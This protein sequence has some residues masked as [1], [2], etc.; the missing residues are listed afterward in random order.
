MLGSGGVLEQHS[1]ALT[2]NAEAVKQVANMV[3]S[4]DTSVKVHADACQKA[5]ITVEQL[6]A[7]AIEACDGIE[8]VCRENQIDIGTRIGRVREALRS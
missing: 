2:A 7:A 8:E 3:T 6:H 5:G 4:H 1:N